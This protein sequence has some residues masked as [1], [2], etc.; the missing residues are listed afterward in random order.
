[1][2]D[3]DLYTIGFLLLLLGILGVFGYFFANT[4]FNTMESTD[5]GAGIIG[6]NTTGPKTVHAQAIGSFQFMDG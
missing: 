3:F 2:G 6:F 1:M 4:I 5:L